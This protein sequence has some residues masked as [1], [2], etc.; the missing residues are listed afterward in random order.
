MAIFED[1]YFQGETKISEKLENFVPRKFL[2]IQYSAW[3][4]LYSSLQQVTALHHK[5]S[6]KE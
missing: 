6:L 3:V 5:M 1:I 4:S 2:A